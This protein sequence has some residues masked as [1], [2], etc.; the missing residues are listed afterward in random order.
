MGESPADVY[1][2]A[3]L[4]LESLYRRWESHSVDNLVIVSHELFIIVFLMRMF[5]YPV[6]DY[7]AFEGLKNCELVVL[8]RANKDSVRFDIAYCWAPGEEKRLGGLLRKP[9][10]KTEF[11]DVE[12][13]DGDPEAPMIE[14]RQS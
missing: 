9:E 12:I 11:H 2:R 7:Y 14:S 5:R 1:N 3:G 10:E 8:E 13:W 4:F 6:H